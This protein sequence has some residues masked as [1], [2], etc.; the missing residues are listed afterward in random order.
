VFASSECRQQGLAEV[1]CKGEG[2]PCGA[3]GR[4]PKA[5]VIIVK[6]D[7]VGGKYKVEIT[8]SDLLFGR[9]RVVVQEES[10]KRCTR[11][12]PIVFYLPMNYPCLECE[13]GPGKGHAM[14]P[15]ISFGQCG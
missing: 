4:L 12:V 10:R 11:W 13:C 3:G 15:C 9:V 5:V 1:D 2:G 6:P 7:D 14:W 8:S